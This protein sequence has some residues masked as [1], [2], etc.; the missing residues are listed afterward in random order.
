MFLH[1]SFILK[2]HSPYHLCTFPK[3]FVLS[4]D[5]AC[6]GL[7]GVHWKKWWVLSFLN[8][9]GMETNETLYSAQDM[10]SVMLEKLHILQN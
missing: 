4:A 10:L 8:F 1:I 9:N 3:H 2:I 6:P 7:N 5:R